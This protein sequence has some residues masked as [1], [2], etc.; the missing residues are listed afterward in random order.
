MAEPTREATQPDARIRFAI[1]AALDELA[2]TSNKIRA[3]LTSHG[4]DTAAIFAIE[5]AIEEITTNAIKYGFPA[6]QGGKITLQASATATRA[7]LIIEDNGQPFDP[8]EVP[9]PEV[10]RSLEDM[11]IGG[12][13]IHLV[14]ALTDGF[15]YKRIDDRNQVHI[16]VQRQ[17]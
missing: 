15:D 5:T 13:G 4:V 2:P 6:C 14:R 8:T 7:E 11:P 10:N 16:W 3:F 17:R 9:D 12:L 1:E